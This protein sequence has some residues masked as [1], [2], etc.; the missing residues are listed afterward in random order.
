MKPE[1]QF[2]LF[3]LAVLGL[4]ALV[5]LPE[6]SPSTSKVMASNPAQIQLTEVQPEASKSQKIVKIEK[7]AA[8]A[9]N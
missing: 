6:K 2:R 5:V 3:S 1:Y 9:S 4:A 7:S 8:Q